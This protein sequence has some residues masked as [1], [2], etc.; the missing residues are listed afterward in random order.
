[1]KIFKASEDV[2]A[3]LCLIEEKEVPVSNG[4]RC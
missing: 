2:S 4:C 1:M 3:L